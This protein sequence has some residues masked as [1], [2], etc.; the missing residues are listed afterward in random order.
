MGITR[1][2]EENSQLDTAKASRREVDDLRSA[3]SSAQVESRQSLHKVSTGLD[4]TLGVLMALEQRVDSMFATRTYV[5]EVTRNIADEIVER[6]DAKEELAKLWKEFDAER[7]RL[8]QTVRQQQNYRKDLNET[9]ENL[10]ELQLGNAGIGKRCEQLSDSIG[11]IDVREEQRWEQGQAA[12]LGQKQAHT[13][14]E[15][16]WQ[17]LREESRSHVDWQRS[18]GERLKH[19]STQRYLEQMDKA[20]NL[21]SAMEKLS[22]DN[23]E[24]NAT[25]RSIKLPKV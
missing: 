2:A 3:A 10:H 25:M 5:D 1:M 8:R 9:M 20:L 18:E 24:M 13:D 12:L 6:S 23:K 14:L 11:A 19:L 21:T 15:V 4:R 17:V 16:S 22:M 7:E